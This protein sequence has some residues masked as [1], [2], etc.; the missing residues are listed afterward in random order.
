MGFSC[1]I[2]GLPNAG[3][4]TIF[5]AL[6][7]AGSA[8]ASY[9]FCTI[10]PKEGKVPVPDQRLSTLAE[11]LKPPTVTPT[12]LTFVDIAGL[13]KNAHQGEGLGNRFLANIRE[14]DAVV[15]VVRLFPDSNVSHVS[16][17]VDPVN[18]FD[19]VA[20][21]LMLA[22]LET[23]TRRKE[24]TEK[25]ARVG[26]K[27]ARKSLDLL[28]RLEASLGQGIPAHKVPA[29][30]KGERQTIH[31]LFLLTSKPSMAVINVGEDQPPEEDPRVAAFR[32]HV[33]DLSIP[34]VPISGKLEMELAELP[35]EDRREFM[36]EMG[37]EGLAL[38]RIVKAGYQL[39]D[40]VTFYTIVGAEMRA[41]TVPAGTPAPQAAGRIHTDM[42]KG[43]IKAEV[44]PYYRFVDAGSE[45]IA[46]NRAFVRT[47]GKDYT[48]ADGDIV[49][50]LFKA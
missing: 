45:S 34:V 23:V 44:V 12:S 22:D 6:T 50:F 29:R 20:T 21:E 17:N 32:A 27:E 11:I 43:F 18:D 8:V 9:P 7:L 2:V 30:N 24:K 38:E 19:V 16:E 41:W 15:H 37:L 49:T 35:E 40:L 46:K 25:L 10:D 26:D 47:E 48:I 39:L 5:N 14:M 42:E 4:S 1:G 33:S 3:K 31:D 36:A 28:H 13:V